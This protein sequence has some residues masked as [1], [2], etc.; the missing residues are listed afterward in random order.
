M[1][2]GYRQSTGAPR[3]QVTAVTDGARL[4]P[5]LIAENWFGGLLLWKGGGIRQWAES[6]RPPPP[7][8]SRVVAD[9]DEAP[10]RPPPSTGC[11]NLSV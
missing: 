9:I 6:T 4:L 10:H 3:Q 1:R 2:P 5:A 7:I 11:S 8:G